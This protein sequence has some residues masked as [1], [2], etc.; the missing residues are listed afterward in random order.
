MSGFTDWFKSFFSSSVT[1]STTTTRNSSLKPRSFPAKKDLTF[2]ETVNAELTRG[3][4][5]NAVKGY[6]LG[7][8]LCY[9]PIKIPLSFMGVP[10]FDYEDEDLL[11]IKDFWIDKIKFYN[12]KIQ[13]K[14]NIQLLC[15][16]DGTS[17]IYPQYNREKQ[18]VDWKHIPI[19]SIA[20]VLVDPYTEKINAIVTEETIT[21][22]D[23]MGTQ[24][25][26]T[27]T[28]IYTE[29]KLI[30]SRSGVLP[31]NMN[32]T[33]T[34]VNPVKSLPIVFANAKEPGEFEG[35]SDYER[36]IPFVKAYSEINQSAHE[37]LLNLLPKLVQGVE[38]VGKWMENNGITDID[39]VNIYTIDFIV[40]KGEKETT[41]FEIPQRVVDGHI[42]LMEKDFANIVE[43]SGLPELAW[44]MTLPGNH[45]T[46]EENMGIL[47]ADVRDKQIQVTPS[48]QSLYEWTL[49]LEAIANMRIVPEGLKITWNDLDTLSEKE[50]SEIFKNYADGISVLV[51][52]SGIDLESIHTMLF[53][54]TNGKITNDFDK[55]RDQI[56]AHGTMISELQQD[57]QSN[58][59]DAAIDDAAGV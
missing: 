24:K 21:Y 8:S 11:D 33:E 58:R 1:T 26:Y 37:T 20:R 19:E 18:A 54:F 23:D 48:Y 5:H 27:E 36:I 41:K 57:P 15:H 6:K 22:F 59:L 7:G 43:T 12:D 32:K 44:G 50:R 30:F 25:N 38:D 3:L 14:K 39:D 34:R 45:A 40:N 2:P 56:Y 31:E 29:S 4:W 17:I 16:R 42:S 55:F 28:V 49:A 46:A 35:H 52:N 47:L 13:A 10:H 9:N 53:E 51:Q